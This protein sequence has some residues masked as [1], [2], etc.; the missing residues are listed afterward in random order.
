[1]SVLLLSASVQYRFNLPQINVLSKADTLNEEEIDKITE[2]ISDPQKLI[3][4]INQEEAG[5]RREISI[6]LG[7]VLTSMGLFNEILPVSSLTFDGMDNLYAV[8]E[9]IFTDREG[10][11]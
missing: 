10:L 1:M 2:W 6:N 4:A 5:L 9:R 11:I 8:L 3:N 7:E